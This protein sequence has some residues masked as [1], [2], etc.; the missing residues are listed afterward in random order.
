[1][2]RCRVGAGSSG[3]VNQGKHDRDREAVEQSEDDAPDRGQGE[4]DFLF[5]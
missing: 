2:N 4:L 3:D 1:M 5:A